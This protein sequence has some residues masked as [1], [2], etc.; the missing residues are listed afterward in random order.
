LWRLTLP[1]QSLLL[2]VCGDMPK[3]FSD[4]WMGSSAGALAPAE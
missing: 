4:R 3:F 2:P 1:E